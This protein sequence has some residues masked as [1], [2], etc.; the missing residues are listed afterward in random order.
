MLGRRLVGWERG[1]RW[2]AAGLAIYFFFDNG[3]LGSPAEKKKNVNADL[4]PYLPYHSRAT[5][6]WNWRF[7]VTSV[8][9]MAPCIKIN[10][11]DYFFHKTRLKN[12]NSRYSWNLFSHQALEMGCRGVVHLKHFLKV[13]QVLAVSYSL[14]SCDKMSQ[15]IFVLPVT[16]FHWHR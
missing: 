13:L 11:G 9:N 6:G 10:Q 2:L 3:L 14:F 8:P 15:H 1:R 12:G 7:D 5:G 16:I 4:H